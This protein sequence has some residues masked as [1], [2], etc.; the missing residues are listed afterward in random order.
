ME[1]EGSLYVVLESIFKIFI[2]FF[3][4]VFK[5]ESAKFCFCVDE[6]MIVKKSNSIQGRKVPNLTLF[7]CDIYANRTYHE[8]DLVR[9]SKYYK[10]V[11][12]VCLFVCP[13]ITQEPLY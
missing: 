13:I 12:S 4:L 11:I 6:L 1:I 5:K 2:P 3:Y 10:V 9:V 7:V 8:F